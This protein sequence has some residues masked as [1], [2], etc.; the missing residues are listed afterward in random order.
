MAENEVLKAIKGRRSVRRYRKDLVSDE[1]L[2][3][4]LE[5]GRWAPSWANTQ[6]WRFV[7]VK[8]EEIRAKLAETLSPHNP[9]TEAFHQ[10]PVVIVGC[11][12]LGRS[13]Y[14][15]GEAT[16]ERGDWFMFDMGIAL[17]NIALAAHSLGLGTVHVGLFD[18]KKVG[19]I[20]N[21]PDGMEAV[22]MLPLGHPDQEPK[23]PHRKEMSELVHYD[24][25]EEEQK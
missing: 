16:T 8:D 5:A 15:K 4:V 2:N 1:D 9:S 18:F 14:K 23:A 24:R 12:I 13:G 11:A 21:L 22:E 3:H 25:F 7:V 6:C 10:A 17:Q 19:K 20:L